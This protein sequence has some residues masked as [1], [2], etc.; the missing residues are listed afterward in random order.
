[1]VWGIGQLVAGPLSD[2]WGRKCL[3]ALADSFTAWTTAVVLLGAGTDMVYPL[4]SP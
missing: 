3:I 4:C 2:R 1:M